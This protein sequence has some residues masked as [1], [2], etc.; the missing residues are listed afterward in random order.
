ME[1]NEYDYLF[2]LLVIGDSGVGKSCFLLRFVDDVYTE[3]YISTIGVDFKIKT[4]QLDGKIIKLQMWDTAGQERFRTITCSY[5]HGANGIIVMYDITDE[6]SFNNVKQWLK[7][8]SR[9][10]SDHVNTLLLGNKSEMEDCRAVSKETAQQ[11]ALT[12]DIDFLETSAKENRNVSAS[13]MKI[14]QKI[15]ERTLKNDI[16]YNEVSHLKLRPGVNIGSDVKNSCC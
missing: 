6:N 11:F 7:E 10:A 3:S 2:K 13:F 15:M 4:I 8:I 9:Y 14:T 1:S 16:E 5:Y 12:H